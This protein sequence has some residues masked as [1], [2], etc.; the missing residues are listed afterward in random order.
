MQ[1][2]E[3]DFIEI[4]YTG[5][6]KD[7]N[8]IF[9]TTSE[10]TARSAGIFNPNAKYK[11]MIVCVGHA[12]LLKGIDKAI[13]GKE[14]NKEY[15]IPISAE[16]GFGK[17]NAELIQLIA[18]PKFRKHGINPMPGLQVNIDNMIGIIKTVS[19]GRTM[20]DFNH[21]CAGKELVYTVKVKR[22]VT[23][24]KE[25]AEAFLKMT[26]GEQIIKSVE[27]KEKKAEISTMIEMPE[28]LQPKVTE[29][30]QK[31]IPE[32]TEVHYHKGKE[33][34]QDQKQ[35]HVHDENCTDCD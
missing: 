3:N 33:K 16:E 28:E 24:T 30:L 15:T 6:L 31:C 22:I 29:Q 2:K 32:I 34:G 5:K 9:D 17:K 14:L 10:E 1:I 19:G 7:D 13:V 20:V 23:D 4:D 11:P 26:L 8:I 27:V 18:T 21:P 25:K 35:D 12:Q